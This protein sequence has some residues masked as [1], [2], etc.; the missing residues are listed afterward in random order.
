MPDAPYR[1]SLALIARDESRCIARCLES[2]RGVVDEL[3]VLDTGSVDDTVALATAAGATVHRFTWVDDFSAARNAALDLCTG[4]WRLVLD[5]DEWLADGA[6]AL[7]A[8]R[9]EAPVFAGLAEVESETNDEQVGTSWQVRVLPRDVRY[10]GR[11]HEQ[12]VHEGEYRRLDVR[13]GH[14][15]YLPAQLDRKAGRNRRLVEAALEQA[16]ND[17][18]LRFQLGK[19]LELTGDL[20][21]A[22]KKYRFAYRRTSPTTRDSAGWRHD[23]VVRLLYVLG[24]IGLTDEAIDV[25][26]AELPHWQRSADFQFG[27]GHVLLKHALANPQAAGGLLPM[28]ESAWLTA[29][30]LGDTP[31][32]TGAVRGKGS[33]L[34]AEN[35]A[36]FYDTLGRPKDAARYRRLALRR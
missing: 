26:D 12:P 28:V 15:G 20:V 19:D 6:E 5:A 3:L 24:E 2:L 31:A 35:L 29:L 22:A 36:M 10:T 33:H 16:P 18:Y 13:I 23:L 14:D 32:F 21:D 25:A 11:V 4:D 34:A 1:L 7:A 30:E 27:L 8:L 17:P 9:H